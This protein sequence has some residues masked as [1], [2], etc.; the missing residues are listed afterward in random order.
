M[1]NRWGE[2]KERHRSGQIE[3]IQ[4]EKQI[5]AMRFVRWMKFSFSYRTWNTALGKRSLRSGVHFIWVQ[6]NNES[7]INNS[8]YLNITR[9]FKRFDD[10]ASLAWNPCPASL[11][12]TRSRCQSSNI[13][14]DEYQ[15]T[16]RIPFPSEWCHVRLDMEPS[17]VVVSHVV[18]RASR[19]RR[20]LSQFTRESNKTTSA[21]VDVAQ[22]CPKTH[23]NRLSGW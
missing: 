20:I 9:S 14:S 1:Q 10:C 4:L 2:Q 11:V 18:S 8:G 13:L 19:W 17:I 12:S 22:R 16:W 5:R 7:S 15:V 3:E 23:I 21:Q 6:I